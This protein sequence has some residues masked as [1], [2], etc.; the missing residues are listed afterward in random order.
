MTNLGRNTACIAT[1][2]KPNGYTLTSKEGK[3]ASTEGGE[4]STLASGGTKQIGKM[5]NE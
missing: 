5:S 4:R 2:K 3:S 1:S